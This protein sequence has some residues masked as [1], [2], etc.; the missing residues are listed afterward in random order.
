LEELEV[1]QLT[2]DQEHTITLATAGNKN[3][4]QKMPE[5]MLNF[6]PCGRRQLGRTLKKLF[7]EAET[8]ILVTD[9]AD[10]IFNA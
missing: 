6:G 4:Q 1:N 7:D 3:E 9:D 5:I 8:A 2:R 10:D